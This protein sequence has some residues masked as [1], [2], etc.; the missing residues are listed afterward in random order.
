MST[1]RDPAAHPGRYWQSK[2]TQSQPT[3]GRLPQ[4]FPG[5]RYAG[6]QGWHGSCR[7]PVVLLDSRNS[8][9][10]RG[11]TLSNL[12]PTYCLMQKTHATL[13]GCGARI[14]EA[15]PSARQASRQLSP[16]CL[17]QE[18]FALPGGSPGLESDAQLL[19]R[20][21]FSA[22]HRQIACPHPPCCQ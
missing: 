4:R 8:K 7:S 12:D 21:G 1:N 22:P 14:I 6:Q 3:D 20:N 17:H 16:K 2:L 18:A 15:D 11:F 9:D 5:C 13:T 19:H 10:P